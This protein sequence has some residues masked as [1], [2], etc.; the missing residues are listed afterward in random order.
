MRVPLPV[1]Q[2]IVLDRFKVIVKVPTEQLPGRRNGQQHG[3]VSHNRHAPQDDD[4]QDG[5][6]AVEKA[7]L[8]FPLAPGDVRVDHLFGH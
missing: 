6:Q 3:H 8:L 1:R 2:A 7:A 5:R 4:G